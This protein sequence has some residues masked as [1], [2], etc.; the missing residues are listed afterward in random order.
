MRP[1]QQS[2][3]GFELG[4]FFKPLLKWWWLIL[5]TTLAAVLSSYYMLSQRPP[6]Y[7][8][9]SSLII[10]QSLDNPN[11]NMGG[12][13]LA[14]QLAQTYV[15]AA[16]R[17]PVRNAAMENLGLDWLPDYQVRPVASTQLIEILVTDTVPE[18]AL[19]TNQELIEQLILLSPSGLSEQDSEHQAVMDELLNR[20]S[21]EIE[22]TVAEEQ[23][24]SARMVEAV[25]A[26]EI[27]DIESELAAT[28]SKL[29]T[30]ENFYAFAIAQTNQEA[31]NS[32]KVFEKPTLP[33]A[34]VSDRIAYY[35][36][37]SGVVGLALGVAAAYLLE[38][39][40]DT[41]K[42]AEDTTR[43]SGLPV[44]AS[45][46]EMTSDNKTERI[47]IANDQ[48]R[49][50]VT[51]VFRSLR[52][53]IQFSN[54]DRQVSTLVV[55]SPVPADGKSTIAANLGVVMTQAGQKVLIID[56][57]LRRPVLHK[58]F[59]TNN[60]SGI[61]N[62]LVRM[63]FQEDERLNEELFD[64]L[65]NKSL[66]RVTD[67]G[68]MLLTSGPIPPNP[69]EMLGSAKMRWFV[70]AFRRRFDITI[71]DTPPCLP[72]TDAVV[73]ST[74]TDG[75]LL[76]AREGKTR[77]QHLKKAVAK[78]DEVNINVTGIVLNRVS[79]KEL[80]YY[81]GNYYSS[82]QKEDKRHRLGR[83]KQP[84]SSPKT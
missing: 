15:E 80:E 68:L 70:E 5:L 34:P 6:L 74:Q 75:V 60:N 79:E 65:L 44:L 4:V 14:G 24:L 3:F 59:K 21:L 55:T 27:S 58:I 64:D 42:S 2:E 83:D 19:A 84:I 49:S 37:A 17:Q 11:L 57:D 78:F 82:D 36:L 81:Y 16:Q 50:H 45:V 53:S 43:V 28:Y 23:A 52:T 1:Y 25:S 72:V 56:T 35:L 31:T 30:L 51:E 40:D 46:A 22:K 10:G 61:T 77:Q 26:R 9:Q 33:T 69:A 41:L 29:N 63:Q 48:P 32:I 8:V 67:S 73:M 12:V 76:V 62:M 38:Y 18:R 47:L 39:L 71:F 13:T 66:K 54:L 20:Y 7:M